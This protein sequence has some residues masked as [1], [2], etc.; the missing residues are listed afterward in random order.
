ME[1]KKEVIEEISN[2]VGKEYEI[3]EYEDDD[4][5]TRVESAKDS[6]GEISLTDYSEPEDAVWGRDL[7]DNFYAGLEVGIR[8]TLKVIKENPELVAKLLS[9]Q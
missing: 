2:L 9:N 5:G 6:F 8:N 7:Q 1:I 4:Y 3:K